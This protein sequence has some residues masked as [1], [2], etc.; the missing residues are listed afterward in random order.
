ML[1]ALIVDDELK[2]RENLKI[3]IE[4][5]CKDVEVVALASTVTEALDFNTLYKPQIVFLDI[6]MNRETGFDFLNKV[7]QIN[8][9]VIFTTAYSE[10]AIE[11]IKFSAID[12]LLKPIDIEE[13]KVSIQRIENKKSS[14]LLKDKLDYLL[15]NIKVDNTENFKLV[16]P[17]LQGLVCVNFKDI[18]FCETAS[19]NT[20]FH[21]RQGQKYMV[22][23]SLKE[24][25]ELLTKYGF[26]RIH[27][28]Y[29]IH[30]KEVKKYIRGDNGYVMMSND[31]QLQVS[32]RKKDP[33]LTKV[34]DGK[35]L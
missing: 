33:F 18:I 10:Y 27:N 13:L 24:Y 23:R 15:Q 29:L 19:S 17:S 16:L 31:T 4:D 25:D 32:K 34:S 2:S 28:A 7:N 21:M 35:A 20:I 22:S 30:L 11:A 12:Y 6:Q 9:E 3:M 1:K 14:F 5:F 8:F 26:F